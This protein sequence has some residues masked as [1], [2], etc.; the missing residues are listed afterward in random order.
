M[1]KAAAVIWGVIFVLR[2]YSFFPLAATISAR[3][4]VIDAF[5]T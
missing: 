3:A 1:T 5:S 2:F 4:L